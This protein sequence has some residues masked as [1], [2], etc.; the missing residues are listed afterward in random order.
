MVVTKN[1]WKVIKG[2]IMIINNKPDNINTYEFW[3][4]KYAN[5]WETNC[6]RN[7]TRE[8]IK[9]LLFHLPYIVKDDICDKSICDTSSALGDGVDEIVKEFPNA[10]VYGVEF[11]DVALNKANIYYP[12]YVF[13]KEL[14]NKYY[15]LISSNTLEHFDHPIEILKQYLDYAK[16]YM[17]VLVPVNEEVYKYDKLGEHRVCF[18]EDSFPNCIGIFHKVFQKIFRVK[19][20]AGEQMLVVYE[21]I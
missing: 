13:H 19:V 4:N 20:W 5:S 21:K 17:I 11:S 14:N 2:E 9:A 6:G 15:A 8:F 12:D 1:H 18:R 10:K 7:Q 16:R 3:E